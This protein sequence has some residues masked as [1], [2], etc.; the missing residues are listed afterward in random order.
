LD[1]EA[2]EEEEKEEVEEVCPLN[3]ICIVNMEYKKHHGSFG[4]LRTQRSTTSFFW[5]MTPR[6][7]QAFRS[8]IVP[9]SASVQRS[10]MKK[11]PSF[12]TPVN[13]CHRN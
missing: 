11:T 1:S 2:T 8:N 5:D 13:I 12:E 10:L 3:Y 9:S 6:H 7:F 4:V